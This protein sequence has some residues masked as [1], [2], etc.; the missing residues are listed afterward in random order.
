MLIFMPK[1][2]HYSAVSN[3]MKATVDNNIK[4]AISR[5]APTDDNVSAFIEDELACQTPGVKSYMTFTRERELSSI[6]QLGIYGEYIASIEALYG[7]AK[8]FT[9]DFKKIKM[10]DIKLMYTDKNAYAKQYVKFYIERAHDCIRTL[11]QDEEKVALVFTFRG[12]NDNPIV[13]ASEENDQILYIYCDIETGFIHGM[14]SGIW[15]NVEMVENI[16][17]GINDARR[18]K[19]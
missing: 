12:K 6:S 9:L 4:S 14:Y 1:I 15:I 5:F 3:K 2:S 18:K 7:S 10:P 13:P 16:L 19:Q 17:G 8:K 11:L